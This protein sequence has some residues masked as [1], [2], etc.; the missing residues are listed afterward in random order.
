MMVLYCCDS[1]STNTLFCKCLLLWQ[2][3]NE[4]NLNVWLYLLALFV[5][6]DLLASRN[7]AVNQLGY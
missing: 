6:V 1:G 5:F 4:A 2:E 7:S 3:V